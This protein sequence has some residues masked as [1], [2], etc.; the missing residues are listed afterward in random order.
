MPYSMVYATPSDAGKDDFISK[1]EFDDIMSAYEWDLMQ[2][3]NLD[4]SIDNASIY[5]T[6]QNTSDMVQLLTCTN[7]LLCLILGCLLC[8][9]F[10]RYI[11]S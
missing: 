11:R 6:A 8:N 10:S 4:T 3:E 1:S 7:V 2:S 9:I 5:T